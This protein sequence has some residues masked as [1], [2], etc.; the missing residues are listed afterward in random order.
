MTLADQDRYF[1]ETAVVA[2]GLGAA[3]VP[4][5][6]AETLACIAA[7]R[8]ALRADSRTREVAQLVMQRPGSTLEALP[9]E[10][11]Q[12]AAVDLL[13]GWARRM[14]GLRASVFSRPIVAGGTLALASTLRWAFR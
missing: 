5:S 12:R 11:I 2:R 1:A 6:R 7:M 3:A 9:L 8:P 4:I 14:H 10:V 13:P